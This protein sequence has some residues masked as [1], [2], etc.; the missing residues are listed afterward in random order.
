MG[1]RRTR[2][3][4]SVIVIIA[5]E[6]TARGSIACQQGVEVGIGGADSLVV[7]PGGLDDGSSS[8]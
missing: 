6:A 5:P 8:C 1:S 2:T 3:A 7:H 4:V